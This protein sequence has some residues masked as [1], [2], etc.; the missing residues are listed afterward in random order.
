MHRVNKKANSQTKKNYKKINEDGPGSNF[1]TEDPGPVSFFNDDRV[2]VNMYPTAWGKHGVEIICPDL[3]YDTGLRTFADETQ[4][5]HYA[6][7]T[8]SDI[9]SKLN[10]EDKMIEA[11]MSRLLKRTSG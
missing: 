3:N 2:E 11:V 6:R 1:R 8:Y 7:N 10:S 9:I 5:T 4:A